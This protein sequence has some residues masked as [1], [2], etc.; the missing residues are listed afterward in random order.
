MLRIVASD[1]GRIGE[2]RPIGDTTVT[3]GRGADAAIVLRDNSVSR[4]HA[5]ID[6]EGAGFVVRDL[7]SANG[8]WVDEERIEKAVLD[9]GQRFRVG[10]TIFESVSIESEGTAAPAGGRTVLSG[11]MAPPQAEGS[12]FASAPGFTV[13]ILGSEV[14]GASSEVPIRERS[15]ILGRSEDCTVTIGEGDPSISRQHLKVE[16]VP[17]GIRVT[18]LGSANGTWIH[19]RKIEGSELIEE[20]TTVRVG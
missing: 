19:D 3:I 8:T 9:P 10:N 5:S 1:Q 15:A 16:L 18:D 11:H 12:V 14:Y 17:E 20:G 6:A 2:E 13:R 7:G 4:R